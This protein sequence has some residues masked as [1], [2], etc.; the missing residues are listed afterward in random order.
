PLSYLD[1]SIGVKLVEDE[2]GRIE[3]GVHA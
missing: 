3:H 2:I 1:T